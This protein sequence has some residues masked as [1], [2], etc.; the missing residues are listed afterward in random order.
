MEQCPTIT[1]NICTY[2]RNFYLKIAKTHYDIIERNM[3][4]ITH[5]HNLTLIKE[6]KHLILRLVS[7]AAAVDKLQSENATNSDYLEQFVVLKD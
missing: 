2:N 4:K 7:S 5:N 3:L 1:R 6:V